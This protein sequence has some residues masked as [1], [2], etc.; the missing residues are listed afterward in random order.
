MLIQRGWR[1]IVNAEQVNNPNRSL[2]VDYLITKKGFTEVDDC[3][4]TGL[5]LCLFKFRNRR[6]QTLFIST[7]N[8]QTGQESTIYKW[9]VD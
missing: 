6:G 7:T 2:I 9:W 8:N 4:G 5:G 1:P 3:A